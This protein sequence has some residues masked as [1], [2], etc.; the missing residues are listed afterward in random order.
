ME[1]GGDWFDMSKNKRKS[2]S[3]IKK[4]WLHIEKIS[5]LNTLQF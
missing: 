4:K 1:G 2:V 5:L 3:E